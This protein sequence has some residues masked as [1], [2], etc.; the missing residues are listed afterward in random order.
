MTGFSLISAVGT[1]R[2]LQHWVL[3]IMPNN[4]GTSGYV[5]YFNHPRELEPFLLEL[6][7]C[8]NEIVWY[9]RE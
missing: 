9:I 7:E 5:P 6:S 3:E 8:D 2:T 4:R 1:V